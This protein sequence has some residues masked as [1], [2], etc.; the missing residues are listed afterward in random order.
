M[1][2]FEDMNIKMRCSNETQVNHE[3]AKEAVARKTI[4]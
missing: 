4:M 1:K 3:N 2:H